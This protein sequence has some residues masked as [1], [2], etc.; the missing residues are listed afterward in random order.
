MGALLACF[1]AWDMLRVFPNKKSW[2]WGSQA[3]GHL[4]FCHG[5]PS[6]TGSYNITICISATTLTHSWSWL[7]VLNEAVIGIP[8]ASLTMALAS[9]KI[10][11]NQLASSQPLWPLGNELA[12]HPL[13]Q[14]RLSWSHQM[15]I[16]SPAE[17]HFC[18]LKRFPLTAPQMLLFLGKRQHKFPVCPWLLAVTEPVAQEDTVRQD[19]WFCKQPAFHLGSHYSWSPKCDGYCTACS[20][21]WLTNQVTEKTWLTL[22]FSDPQQLQSRSKW[23]EGRRHSIWNLCLVKNFPASIL[24]SVSWGFHCVCVLCVCW[25][26]FV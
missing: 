25:K 7:P 5:W 11:F 13:G 19:W 24:A 3:P 6:V 22:L 18:L 21:T 4:P 2:S 23:W 26:L 15:S 12:S 8:W 1:L 20:S 9:P 10:S 14:P 17:N 16:R